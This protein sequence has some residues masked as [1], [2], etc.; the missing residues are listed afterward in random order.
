MIISLPFLILSN[1]VPLYGV[2]NWGWSLNVVMLSYWF[3]NVIIAIITLLKMK[4]SEG[5]NTMDITVNGV[6]RVAS[7][8][9]VMVFF[10]LHYG[11]FAFV[12]GVFIMFFFGKAPILPFLLAIIF[13]TASHAASYVSNYIGSDEYK[14]VSPSDLFYAPYARVFP[15][16]FAVIVGAIF[17][18]KNPE[19]IVPLVI[20]ILLKTVLDAVL[21]MREHAKI[22]KN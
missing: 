16:H 11:G 13:T 7:R 22:T 18:E 9:D 20:L 10:A 6:K 12:H 14:R 5:S 15:L 1:M 4:R 2:L 3:E 21:H 17:I 19:N 8:R